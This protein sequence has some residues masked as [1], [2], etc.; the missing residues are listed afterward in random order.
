M[1]KD[2]EGNT[3]KKR[4][5]RELRRAIIMGQ[6]SPGER[7]DV[8]AIADRFNISITPVRDALNMLNQEG[9]VTIKPRS[10][11]FV[12]PITLK[13]LRDML[14]L[15]KIL[16]LAA[17]DI[18]IHK[19]TDAQI[20]PLRQVHASYTG[21]DDESYDRYTDENRLFHCLIAQASGNMEL[22]KTLGH[23]LD[24]LARFMVFQR[25]GKSMEDTHSQIVAAL[26]AHDSQAARN[27]LLN[28]I[29]NSRE[30]IIDGIIEEAA[31]SWEL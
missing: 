22:T 9:L 14:E 3:S 7:L 16:E 18:A 2:I 20:E 19:I 15:R 29:E 21:D 24:R 23:L 11:Y 27:A 12:T 13:E 5:F 26:Q 25:A 6:S 8:V 31:G 1:R 10:G 17:I 30:A 4:I 28:D